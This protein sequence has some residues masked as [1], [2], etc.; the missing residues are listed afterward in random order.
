MG[1]LTPRVWSNTICGMNCGSSIRGRAGDAGVQVQLLELL[2]LLLLLELTGRPGGLVR[3][4]AAESSAE[5][6]LVGRV[7]GAR[8]GLLARVLEHRRIC[9][10]TAA[11]ARLR[12]VPGP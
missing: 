5:R 12:N 1:W 6:E 10:L 8:D 4:A 2:G 3:L 7:L 11:T 9:G